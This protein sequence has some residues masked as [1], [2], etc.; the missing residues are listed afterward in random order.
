MDVLCDP[1]QTKMKG[2]QNVAFYFRPKDDEWSHK[3]LYDILVECEKVDCFK[4]V[5]L[6]GGS[7]TLCQKPTKESRDMYCK[8]LKD[9]PKDEQVKK[10]QLRPRSQ[11]QGVQFR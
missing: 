1:R 2:V 8:Y 10:D 3:R 4:D 11:P 5:L 7:L 6:T 9:T